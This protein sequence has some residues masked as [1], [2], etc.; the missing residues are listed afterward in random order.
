MASTGEKAMDVEDAENE[1][2]VSSAIL[3]S[4]ASRQNEVLSPEDLAWVESCLV[5]DSDISD[6]D[7][8]PLKNALL[9]IISSQPQSF[10]T[11]GEDV[12]IPPY[13]IS[14]EY[15]NTATTSDE[16]LNLQ[17]STSDEKLI[18]L[19]S[20]TSDEKLILQSS[21][22]DGKHLSEPSSTYNVNSLLMA[23]ETSTDE[24]PDDEKTGTLPSINPFLP[25][26]KEHLKEENETIDS[27]LNLDSSS[28]EME[29]LAENIFKIWDFDIQSEEGE[30]VKQLDKA[31]S[32][33]SFQTVPPSFDDSLKLK[34]S[35]L[36]DLIAGIADLSLN[37][38]V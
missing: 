30:L 23:V 8:I 37:K 21:T 3:N 12:K 24:I 9:D 5:K 22:S 28:Y 6:T 4:I 36:D 10:S 34:D 14:S 20:S 38:N 35:S 27:G 33:N 16:K 25:T 1:V 13:I 29:H 32:E 2:S 15:A 18:I 19:Q 26:Y 11:E 17:S 31:L 7:W